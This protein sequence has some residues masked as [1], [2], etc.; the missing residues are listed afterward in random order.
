MKTRYSYVS[1][2]SDKAQLA[3]V[4]ELVVL[5]KEDLI[6]DAL[7]ELLIDLEGVIDIDKILE[8]EVV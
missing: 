5:E 8:T 3:I 7:G 6:G 2:L 4:N 1:E